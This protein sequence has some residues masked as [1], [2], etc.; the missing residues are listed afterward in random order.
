MTKSDASPRRRLARSERRAQI[1]DAAEAAFMSASYDQ[2]SLM[3][4]ARGAGASDAL[5]VRYF[6]TKANLYLA[7][8]ERRLAE[9]LMAQEESDASAAPDASPLARLA[10]GL[11]AYLDFVAARPRAWA[12]Q[13]LAPDGEPAGAA[14]FRHRWRRRYAELIRDRGNL[15][16]HRLIDTALAGFIALNEAMCFEWVRRDCPDDERETI[17]AMGVAALNALLAHAADHGAHRSAP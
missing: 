4:I 8:W 5:I 9:L 15:P 6:E 11:H 16:D 17:V 14:W 7:V 10:A 12:Q 3:A 13:F 1:L 2:V